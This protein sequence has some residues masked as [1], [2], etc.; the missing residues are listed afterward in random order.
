M[1]VEAVASDMNAD[2]ISEWAVRVIKSRPAAKKTQATMS[3]DQPLK[4]SDPGRT[5]IMTPRKPTTIA[6][7]R[8]QPTGSFSKTAAPSVTA[9]GSAC[10]MAEAL[11]ISMWARPTRNVTVASISPIERPSTALLSSNF[12]GRNAPVF[13]H[14]RNIMIDAIRPRTNMICP[15]FNSADASFTNVSLMVKP[16][17]ET[18]MN[19]A[20]R[21]LGERA[22]NTA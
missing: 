8:R 3:S 12:G 14:S 6:N 4:P 18:A 19:S 7:Q 15:A 17:M 20:P 10:K 11:A 9:S 2:G 16:A 5:M 22:K 21:K 13:Q 1:I